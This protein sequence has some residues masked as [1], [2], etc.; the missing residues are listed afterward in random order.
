M[1][2]GSIAIEMANMYLMMYPYNLVDILTVNLICLSTI[3][4]W[5]L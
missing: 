2:R 1:A 5:E 4:S 3:P